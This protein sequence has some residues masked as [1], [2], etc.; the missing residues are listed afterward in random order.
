M[1]LVGGL[2][3]NFKAEAVVNGGETVKDFSLEQ[4]LGKN[5]VIL[6]ST[7]RTLL[8][9]VPLSYTLSKKSSQSLKKEIVKLLPAQQILLK[10]TGA[11]YKFQKMMVELKE[12][13]IH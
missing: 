7:Q 5:Y 9:F 11:G 3:P 6:F 1:G 4:F 2:A 8:L 13:P 12:S 10:H